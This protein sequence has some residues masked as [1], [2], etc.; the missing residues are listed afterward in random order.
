M[1]L[2]NQGGM[3][4]SALETVLV[5]GN[6]TGLTPAQRVDYYARV[7]QSVGLNPLTKPFQYI[8]FQGSLTLYAGRNCTDQLA[9][10]HGISLEVDS[11]RDVQGTWVVRANGNRCQ[12][13]KSGGHRRRC[14]GWTER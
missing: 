7:C 13:A 4:F 14:P 8:T 10:I 2:A 9:K 5:T 11:G 3:D 6:L 12:R 1:T